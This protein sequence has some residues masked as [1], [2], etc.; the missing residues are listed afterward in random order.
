M[1][2]FAVFSDSAVKHDLPIL[3]YAKQYAN[4]QWVFSP[5]VRTGR[6]ATGKRYRSFE[7]CLPRWTGGLDR[8]RSEEVF[9]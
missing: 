1:R 9:D 6:K 8:T 7:K 4:G 3:G 2:K 5:A